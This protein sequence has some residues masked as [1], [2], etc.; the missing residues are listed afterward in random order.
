MPHLDHYRWFLADRPARAAAMVVHGLNMKPENMDSVVELLRSS[1]VDTLRLALTGHRGDAGNFRNITRKTWLRDFAEGHAAV[2]DH[3]REHHVPQHFVGFSLGGLLVH[4]FL[5]EQRSARF[6]RM[7][8]L[9][10]AIALTRQAIVVRILELFRSLG[11]V[12]IPSLCHPHY[13]ANEGIPIAAYNALLDSYRR[14]H[15]KHLR[16]SN[17]P[18]LV[19]AHPND[20]LVSATRIKE[21]IADYKLDQW[22][23]LHVSSTQHLLRLLYHHI[24]TDPDTLGQKEWERVTCAI[25]NHFELD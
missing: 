2:K 1:G 9:A 7:V 6:D 10:P 18:S 15:Q 16:T 12:M 13:R 20:E 5:C 25:R 11:H 23:L 3:A 21:L 14:I 8:L 22:S 19:I 4:D 17:I 24:I